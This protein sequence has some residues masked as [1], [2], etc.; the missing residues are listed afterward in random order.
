MAKSPISEKQFNRLTD[1]IEWS[2][3]S[4]SKPREDRITSIKN[5][6][7][8]HYMANGNRKIMPVNG[9]KLQIDIY[10]RYLAA[11]HPRAMLSTDDINLQ[12]TVTDFELALN[13]VPEEI[14]LDK[15]LEK[16]VT[17]AL[18]SPLGMVKCGL[19]QVGHIMGYNYGEPFVDNITLDDYFCDMSAKEWHLRQYEGN[20]YW[21]EFED[22]KAL[23]WE[24]TKDVTSDEQ[25]FITEGGEAH[26]SS[27][28]STS[29]AKVFRK[30]IWLRDVWLTKERLMLT[31]GVKTKKLFNVVEYDDDEP[32]PYIPLGFFWVPGNLLPLAPI[33]SWIDLNEL[34]NALFRKLGDSA[35][36]Y[37]RISLFRN[38]DDAEIM[39]FK[40]TR[41]GEGCKYTGAKPEEVEVG[42][43]DPR[44]L[45]LQKLV[46]EYQSY[47]SGSI[48]SLGGLSPMSSTIG[49][50]KLL[51][52]SASA[53]VKKMADKTSD[54][55]K[56]IFKALAY[57]E[58]NNPIKT[59]TI[60]KPLP[61]NVGTINFP[62]NQESR[63]GKFT[64]YNINIDEYSLQ[65]NSPMTQLQKL[66]A[67]MQQYI[68]PAMPAIQQQGGFVDWKFI[69]KEA[70]RLANMS[71][72][73]DK[74]VQFP[75]D[76]ITQDKTN[77]Q[78]YIGAP[79]PPQAGQQEQPMQQDQD[80]QMM[81][82]LMNM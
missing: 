35:D 32:A 22:F 38:G 73:G 75:D 52:D 21:M 59:R 78:Q 72:I 30:R 7:G 58:W 5:L 23:Q 53:Q 71:N 44:S 18:I 76:P 63:K 39:A 10:T 64:D 27:I 56:E 37:K 19:A 51:A 68:Y 9:V 2:A 67:F 11:R 54:F 26:A 29:T 16:C 15:T 46:K 12:P 6:V 1:S 20:D 17:E 41:H 57:Y 49:Q 34:N 33:A 28:S 62:W 8:K 13:Q 24:N 70:S 74:I 61:N 77:Q 43:I 47:Y 31:Y 42:G 79:K 81:D 65:D 25:E 4:F 45:I 80:Q 3:K 50:D 40:N 69:I 82:K 66:G 55:I 36:A 60:K 48:D 14:G